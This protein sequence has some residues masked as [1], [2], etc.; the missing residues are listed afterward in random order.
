MASSE[1]YEVVLSGGAPW[2]FR[3][4]G[5]KEFG[6]PLRIAKV[7]PN[8]KAAT[9]GIVE[10]LLVRSINSA[11]CE[12]WTHSDALNSIKRTGSMLKLILCRKPASSPEPNSTSDSF[13]TSSVSK[14][15]D[16]INTGRP[17]HVT[18][19][20]FKPSS[21][22]EVLSYATMPRGSEKKE[23]DINRWR[24]VEENNNNDAF[25]SQKDHLSD[26]NEW[27][28]DII[29]GVV[30]PPEQIKLVH[31]IEAI[32]SVSSSSSSSEPSVYVK[33]PADARGF[34]DKPRP[35]GRGGRRLTSGS[36]GSEEEF[37]MANGDASSSDSAPS[38]TNRPA[39]QQFRKQK[40]QAAVEATLEPKPIRAAPPTQTKPRKY[41]D[42]RKIL[43]T[44]N[45]GPHR[46]VSYTH[47][48][49]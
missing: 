15:T 44:T 26:G 19:A 42:E 37:N 18:K 24:G 21:S 10:G 3:L 46:P 4:Q 23:A 47:V 45:A 34:T 7:T 6:A 17:S 2:G 38:V 5:G 20:T 36:I 27:N 43:E 14:T 1:V 8:S 40:E 32:R 29:S 9:A 49:Q 11:N 28:P 22:N 12:D 41:G 48:L 39:L 31:G 35:I 30:R 13:F 25:N 16:D 33:A